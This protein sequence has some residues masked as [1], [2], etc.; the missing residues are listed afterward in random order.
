MLALLS[1]AELLGMSL[2]FSGSAVAVQIGRIWSLDTGQTGWLTTIVQLGF[3]CG[4]ALS[5]ILNLAD[6]VESRKLFAASAI[7]GALANG[8]L[9][10]APGFEAALTLRFL[11]GFFL[12]GVYPPA[13]KMIATWFRSQRGLAIGTIVGAWG[14]YQMYQEKREGKKLAIYG[15]ALNV[16]GS[17]IAAIGGSG[18]LVGW[19]FGALISFVIYYLIVISRF[20]GE[21]ALAP[22][23]TA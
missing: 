8:A 10:I 15:V 17:L 2:W 16:V 18:G 1:M 12:A 9:L 22:T 14:G 4:T 3:V 21:P 23:T 5:A 13:M 11:T 7:A 6:I 19:I 20:P